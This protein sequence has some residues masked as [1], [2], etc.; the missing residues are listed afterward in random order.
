MGYNNLNFDPV[1]ILIVEDNPADAELTIRALKKTN[2]AV[3][4]FV[5]I[6]G[7]EA[8]EFIFAKGRYEGRNTSIPLKVIFL[9]LK[10]PKISG[11]EVLKIV[12][13]DKTSR[14]LPV[15]IVSSSREHKDV[16]SA[17]DLGANGYIVKPV[18]FESFMSAIT[19]AGTYWLTVNESL[20]NV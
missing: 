6:D 7:E 9:D 11:L 18:D 3:R 15:V 2:F 19:Y 20:A 4:V 5:V 1:D 10:L 8:L 17:Y 16:E 12:K 13:E 14:R